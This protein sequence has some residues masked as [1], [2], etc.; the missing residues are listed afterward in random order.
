MR[1]VG[2]NVKMSVRP[3]R[4]QWMK[5]R[6]VKMKIGGGERERERKKEKKRN[7]R[8]DW[9]GLAEPASGEG[10]VI[11]GRKRG[12]ET[13][14]LRRSDDLLF[15]VGFVRAVASS[16]APLVGLTVAEIL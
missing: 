9:A 1:K 3:P 6:R 11:E 13:R 4:K 7:E 12:E 14:N 10:E 8:L 2:R 16:S 5:K 15:P